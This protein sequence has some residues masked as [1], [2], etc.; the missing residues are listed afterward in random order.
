MPKPFG[1]PGGRA[2]SARFSRHAKSKL[3]LIRKMKQDVLAYLSRPA[4]EQAEFE[5]TKK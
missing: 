2:I 1:G 4:R 3:P 5:F